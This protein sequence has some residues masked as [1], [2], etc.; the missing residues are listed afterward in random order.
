[1]LSISIVQD[2]EQLQYSGTRASS[3]CTTKA[4]TKYVFFYI[5]N[6]S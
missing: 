4:V 3:A 2:V 6:V 1:M 5:H